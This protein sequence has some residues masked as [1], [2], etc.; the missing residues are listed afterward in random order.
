MVGEID[1]ETTNGRDHNRGK[2]DMGI[3][4][5]LNLQAEDGD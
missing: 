2:G 3:L 1:T 4:R 5:D